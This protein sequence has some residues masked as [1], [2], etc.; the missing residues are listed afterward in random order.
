MCESRIMRLHV[1]S[2]ELVDP[3]AVRGEEDVDACLYLEVCLYRP[4]HSDA[5]DAVEY[6]LRGTELLDRIGYDGIRGHQRQSESRGGT[7]GYPYGQ[8]G[9]HPDL[10]VESRDIVVVLFRRV[11]A[12]TILEEDVLPDLVSQDQVSA[13]AVSDAE[14]VIIEEVEYGEEADIET[15]HLLR[16]GSGSC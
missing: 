7:P 8:E 12:E 16:A 1:L 10:A 6:G 5:G 9:C 3:V 4:C 15:T 13:S 2:V 11:S 14:V